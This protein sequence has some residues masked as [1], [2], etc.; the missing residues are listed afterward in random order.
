MFDSSF[1]F[2]TREKNIDDNTV[3]VVN[4]FISEHT[5]ENIELIQIVGL[6]HL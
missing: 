4:K 3:F 6:F 2:R 5:E 1:R